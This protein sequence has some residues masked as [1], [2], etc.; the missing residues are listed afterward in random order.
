MMIATITWKHF[1]N[2][3][4]KTSF[5]SFCSNKSIFHYILIIFN[6]LFFV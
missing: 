3:H 1:R 6:H 4:D 5:N 2:K